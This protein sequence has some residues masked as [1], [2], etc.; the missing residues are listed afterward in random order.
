MNSARLHPGLPVDLVAGTTYRMQPTDGDL[1]A[2]CTW[3]N[4][5]LDEHHYQTL[6]C[7]VPGCACVGYK[8]LAFSVELT[9]LR[10]QRN[11]NA[12]DTQTSMD[13][14]RKEVERAGK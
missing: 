13:I 3:C 4:H 6:V 9:G 2:E 1:E 7:G 5:R 14:A 10:K 8:G 11:P 12:R